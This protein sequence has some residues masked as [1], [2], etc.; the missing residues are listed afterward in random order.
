MVIESE[1]NAA[2]FS[3]NAAHIPGEGWVGVG[4]VHGGFTE[5]PGDRTGG[6]FGD[7]DVSNPSIGMEVKLQYH[8]AAII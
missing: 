3:D 7:V 6:V 8:L 4:L 5:Q 2:R 1:L